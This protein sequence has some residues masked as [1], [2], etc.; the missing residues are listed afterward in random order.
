VASTFAITAFSPL[1]AAFFDR[2]PE[3]DQGVSGRIDGLVGDRAERDTDGDMPHFFIRT[4]PTSPNPG[5]WTHEHARDVC[6]RHHGTLE[7]VWVDDPDD[8]QVAWI[9]VKDGDRDGLA[10]DF[11][12]LD[13]VTLHETA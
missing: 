6:A 11:H 7:H 10:G 4:A 13:V 1:S 3:R 12:A 8:P 9:L 5:R 2:R